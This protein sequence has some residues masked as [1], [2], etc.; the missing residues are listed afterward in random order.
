MNEEYI[1]PEEAR[2]LLKIT[3]R[4]LFEWSKQG[5]I[6]FITTK[7]G[8]RRYL[9]KEIYG[10]SGIENDSKLSYCY[11]RVN[12]KKYKKELDDQINLLQMKYPD[13]ILIS[14][15]GSGINLQRK[16]FKQILDE[17]IKGNVREVVITSPDR[18][19]SINF[20]FF[21]NLFQEYSNGKILV[22]KN[23]DDRE[24]ESNDEEENE[25]EKEEKEDEKEEKEEEKEEQNKVLN[26]EIIDDLLTIMST[27]SKK[28]PK[29]KN[30]VLR[31]QIKEIIK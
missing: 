18:L 14:E 12:S 11:C 15:Y 23:E 16:G 29:L 10:L 21:K 6:N 27:F 30:T 4:T 19:C 28:L 22:Y 1:R 26:S 7:G 17:V 31:K 8:H 2:R 25:E 13:H 5:K 9:K 24:Y 20:D 3:D